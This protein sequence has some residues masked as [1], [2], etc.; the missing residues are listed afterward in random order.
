[1][2]AASGG[3]RRR[4][5]VTP[6]ELLLG[7]TLGIALGAA[8]AWAI[9]SGAFGSR[10][11]PGR[12]LD[13]DLRTGAVRFDVEA[14]TA[15]VY[16]RSVDNRLVIVSGADNCNTPAHHEEL[17]AYSAA[18]GALRWH[19][20]DPGACA[21][22]WQRV[23]PTKTGGGVRIV[24]T[25]PGAASNTATYTA[26][27]QAT[28]RELWQ[29]S[30]RTTIDDGGGQVEAIGNGMALFVQPGTD[31]LDAF[32]L[33][34]GALRWHRHLDSWVPGGASQVVAGA[35]AVAV[36]DQGAIT[37][38]DGATGKRRWMKPLTSKGMRGHATAAIGHGQVVVPSTS[39]GYGPVDE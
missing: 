4:A 39:T 11:H 9:W 14:R 34:S 37:V 15:A 35:G 12:V 5:R 20:P 18:T 16:V 8:F 29:K 26:Y 25:P 36:I 17:D 6:I 7:A 2:D 19:R 28:G 32:D 33:R 1:V 24:G 13:L 10:P 23:Y 27:D 38:L 22:T 3:R 31:T 30:R 21:G